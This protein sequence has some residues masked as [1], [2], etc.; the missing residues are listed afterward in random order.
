MNVV[1]GNEIIAHS[2]FPV[3]GPKSQSGLVSS[4]L[5]QQ[6]K[7]GNFPNR[8]ELSKEPY[9]IEVDRDT[10]VYVTVITHPDT[11]CGTCGTW[12]KSDYCPACRGEVTASDSV[13]A[14]L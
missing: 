2:E 7:W 10:T 12:A 14:D 9:A 1:K 3:K 11:Q 6:V 13:E 8:P 5:D 4:L